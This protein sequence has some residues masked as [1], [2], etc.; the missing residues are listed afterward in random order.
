MIKIKLFFFFFQ[1]DD[2]TV[3]PFDELSF[4]HS[5]SLLKVS[6]VFCAAVLVDNSSSSSNKVN[7]VKETSFL[8]HRGLSTVRSA[9]VASMVTWTNN[10]IILS[11]LCTQVLIFWSYHVVVSLIIRHFCF[12]VLFSFYTVITMKITRLLPI[13]SISL[14]G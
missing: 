6:T 14:Y 8:C 11:Q 12:S 2:D 13:F 7:K 9:N 10:V 5:I 3:L 1:N 4:K